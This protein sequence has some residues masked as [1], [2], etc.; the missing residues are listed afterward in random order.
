MNVI[1][2]ILI[3]GLPFA[4][5]HISR[6]AKLANVLSPVVLCYAIGLVLRNFTP[7]G[8]SMA[9]IAKL[10]SEATIALAIPMILMN[11]DFMDF[12][13]SGRKYIFSFCLALLAVI[14]VLPMIALLYDGDTQL[15]NEMTAILSG[16]YTGG[17]PN[18]AAIHKAIDAEDTLFGALNMADIIIGGSYLMFLTSIGPSLLRKLFPNK[19]NNEPAVALS[20]TN[21]E[22]SGSFYISTMISLVL[23]MLVAGLTAALCILLFDKLND[24]F[25]IIGITVLG[26]LISFSKHKSRLHASYPV[27]DYLLL[28]FSLAIGLL[29]DFDA[30]ADSSGIVVVY[31]ALVMYTAILFHLLLARI[32]GVDA[33]TTIITSAACIFGPVFI[34]QIV[35]TMANKRLLVPG[36]AMGLAG[37]AVGSIIGIG[38]YWFLGQ[39]H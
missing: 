9:T 20:N 39:V 33:E 23:A 31:S 8:E 5:K 29:S 30:L 32:F 16:G 17:T 3:I 12:F 36:M 15:I 2:A 14:I 1:I 25:F 19:T 6:L 27:G 4:L 37:Y 38:I 34:G 26:V 18:M 11:A 24:G 22:V 28:I 13:R 7:Y 35:S 10:I 21:V